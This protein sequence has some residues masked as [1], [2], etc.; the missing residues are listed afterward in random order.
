MISW[1]YIRLDG[2][3]GPAWRAIL[4]AL[5]RAID[6]GSVQVGDLLPPQRLMADFMGVHVNTVNRAMREAARL[7]LVTARSRLGTTVIAR[8]AT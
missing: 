5:E 6:T 3:R 2:Q 4:R 8:P 1:H 7:G